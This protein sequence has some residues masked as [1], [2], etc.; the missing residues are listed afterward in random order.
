MQKDFQY[1]KIAEALR[2]EVS[3][4]GPNTALPTEHQLAKRFEVSRVTVRHALDHLQRSGLIT[5]QR[6]RGTTTNP[7]KITRHTFPLIWLEDDLKRQGIA[8][9][10]RV[11]EHDVAH[12]P[13]DFVATLLRLDRPQPVEYLSLARL[14]DNRV[15]CHEA[16]YFAVA[17]ANKLTNE[18]IESRPLHRLLSEIAGC[19]ID[20]VELTT[21]ILPSN[22]SVAAAMNVNPGTLI[23]ANTYTHWLR[24]GSLIEAGV[25][26]YRLD[27]C[28]FK[29]HGRISELPF[30]EEHSAPEV[31]R[32]AM[33]G[34]APGG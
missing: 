27:L 5:R 7:P 1:V 12:E 9:E 30:Q 4:L 14:V 32:V 19:H 29:A 31:D 2:T 16:R 17:I 11:L 22:T 6:G 23:L 3:A 10:T 20:T 13:P 26:S 8:Y 34:R 25:T 24:D 18:L 28:K 15:F 21:E 33:I